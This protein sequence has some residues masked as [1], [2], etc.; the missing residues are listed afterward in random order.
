TDI[1][2]DRPKLYVFTMLRDRNQQVLREILEEA[3]SDT[4]AS[5]DS[6]P[7][8]VAAFY[9]SGMDDATADAA[10]ARPLQ[11][12]FDRIEAIRSAAD[13]PEQAATQAKTVLAMET[14]LAKASRARADLR[15]PH[16]NYHKL[17]VAD[18]EKETGTSWKAYLESLGLGS[19]E[20][21]NVGQPAFV[22]ELG[23]M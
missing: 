5:K 9:R 19:L 20:E 17:T 12:E 14:R 7:G 16:L 4:S 2:P 21:L 22:Q 3:A 18:L 10:G 1:P 6:I 11:P 15:D 8:K 13:V 23:R